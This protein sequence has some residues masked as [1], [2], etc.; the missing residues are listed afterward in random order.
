MMVGKKASFIIALW[1]IA[2]VLLPTQVHAATL[3]ESRFGVFPTLTEINWEYAPGMY[4][5]AH[6]FTPESLLPTK[7]TETVN[8]NIDDWFG[9]WDPKGELLPDED[10]RTYDQPPWDGSAWPSG[11]EPYDTEAYYFD[12]D[13]N[14]LYI[15]II[16]G[17]PTPQN[18]IFTD[19]RVGNYPIVQGDLALDFG[20]PH[21]Q[22]D[23]TGF[24]YN[25]GIDITPDERPSS[26]DVQSFYQDEVGST[27]YQTDAGWYLG[28]P[29]VAV[30]P[31]GTGAFT[32]F[33]P[34]HA[35]FSGTAL[36]N[37]KVDW[38][39]LQFPGG[40]LE[41]H[42]AT[43]VIEVTIPWNLVPRLHEGDRIAY[44]FLTGC[45]NDGNQTE[46]FLTGEGTVAT[47]EPGTMAL[48]A[49]AIP[50]I[51]WLRSRRRQA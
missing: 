8:Y 37:V 27:L 31:L 15:A 44:R 38:Y 29:D 48:L 22:T 20:L 12:D 47:P 40:L 14:N 51:L 28:S 21:G 25:F 17:S 46:L 3:L 23:G 7:N 42:W 6:A 18:G 41:N 43:W 2:A 50:G 36:G 1:A 39:E 4:Y 45:R 24:R 26:G 49:L 10:G 9:R 5:N 19:A 32:N 30:D 34:N 35:S 11:D 33:D 16:T 13:E